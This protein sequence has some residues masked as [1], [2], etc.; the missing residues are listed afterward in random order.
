VIGVAALDEW[1]YPAPFTNHGPWV[2]ACAVGVNLVSFFFDTFEDQDWKFHGY[3]GHH[4]DTGWARW[5]GTSFA[6]PQVV[7]RLAI[8]LAKGKNRKGAIE[9][10]LGTQDGKLRYPNFGT[11]VTA[12]EA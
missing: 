4:F 7:A 9:S 11:V 5:T 1:G 8:Q 6:A 3:Q 10:V 2:Q 12:F